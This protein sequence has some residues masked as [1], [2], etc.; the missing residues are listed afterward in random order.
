[1]FGITVK[2]GN[3]QKTAIAVFIFVKQ[4]IEEIV[5]KRVIHDVNMCYKLI[6][7]LLEQRF[8]QCQTFINKFR[9]I[10]DHY[11]LPIKF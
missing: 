9:N 2:A 6:G 8:L 11:L 4:T 10:I 1:M 5:I 7:I 3:I